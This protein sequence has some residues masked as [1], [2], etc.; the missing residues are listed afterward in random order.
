M[1]VRLRFP[2]AMLIVVTGSYAIASWV[3]GFLFDSGVAGA[4]C[5][6]LVCGLGYIDYAEARRVRMMRG[7]DAVWQRRIDR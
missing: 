4:I 2:L 5:A 7:R 6:A 3:F 1:V